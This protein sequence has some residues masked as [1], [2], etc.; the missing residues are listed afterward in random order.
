[1]MKE[2]IEHMGIEIEIRSDDDPINP[3]KDWD[4]PG[5]HMV[6]WHRNYDLGDE[7][8]YQDS[9]HFFVSLFY[10]CELTDEQVRNILLYIVRD[11]YGLRDYKADYFEWR[12]RYKDKA[13]FRYDF[14]KNWVN[15]QRH[16]LD[17]DLRERIVEIVEDHH[18][19]LPLYLYDHS[20]ITM[21]TGRFSCPWD[22]G[23]VGYIHMSLKDAA[24]NWSTPMDWNH[25]VD[26]HDGKPPETLRQ[27]AIDLLEGEVEEYD[28]YLTGD[29]WE[30]IIDEDGRDETSSR[31]FF[32]YDCCVQE[33]KFIAER[34]AK[35]REE[36][37]ARL[38]T[39]SYEI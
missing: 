37:E 30:Y 8:D 2:T 13:S 9:D 31:P 17:E 25:P 35:R 7:H 15:D 34:I 28:M 24:E 20:G 29:V 4:H 11:E 5:T 36:I 3:R 6:C 19:I 16:Y 39:C 21:S 14:I 32:G 23:Q 38:A 18:A 22:S 33:A 26:Y 12:D 27:R 10:E 1:M